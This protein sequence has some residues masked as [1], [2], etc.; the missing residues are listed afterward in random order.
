MAYLCFHPLPVPMA[1]RITKYLNKYVHR[2]LCLIYMFSFLFLELSVSQKNAKNQYALL[3]GIT[4]TVLA[5]HVSSVIGN[6]RC[7]GRLDLHV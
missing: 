1:A 4:V 6:F 5:S 3:P 2:G 7:S